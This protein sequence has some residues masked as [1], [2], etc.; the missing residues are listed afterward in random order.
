MERGVGDGA[1][2]GAGKQQQEKEDARIAQQL[3]DEFKRRGGKNNISQRTRERRPH[4]VGN[5]PR[6]ADKAIARASLCPQ[7]LGRETARAVAS[8]ARRGC[9]S[10]A[11]PKCGVCNEGGNEGGGSTSGL[12]RV[13]V[14]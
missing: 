6:R 11:Q 9:T 8:I 3:E 7:R 5:Y 12:V 14:R 1:G 2:A 13:R 10:F 4:A